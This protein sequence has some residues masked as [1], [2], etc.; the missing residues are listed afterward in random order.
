M[1][2]LPPSA[3]GDDLAAGPKGVLQLARGWVLRDF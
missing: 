3:S 1:T 2:G